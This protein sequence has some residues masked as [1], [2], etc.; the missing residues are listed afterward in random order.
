MRQIVVLAAAVA[1][2]CLLQK[3]AGSA[4]PTAPEEKRKLALNLVKAKVIKNLETEPVDADALSGYISAEQKK[5]SHTTEAGSRQLS[6]NWF[7]Q[8]LADGYGEKMKALIRDFGPFDKE[9]EKG[10]LQIPVAP[11]DKNIKNNFPNGF[12]NARNLAIDKQKE[13]VKKIEYPSAGEFESHEENPDGLQNFLAG[14]L[15]QLNGVNLFDENKGWLKETKVSGIIQKAQEERGQQKSV[16]E[17]SEGGNQV[18]PSRIKANI[19][20]EL[21][22]SVEGKEFGIFPSV[23]SGTEPRSCSLAA[24]KFVGA[25]GKMNLKVPKADIKAFIGQDLEGHKSLNQSEEKCVAHFQESITSRAI[26]QYIKGAPDDSKT[27]LQAFLGRVSNDNEEVKEALKKLTAE[28]VSASLK[29]A[30]NELAEGQLTKFFK[31]LAG[32]T[33]KPPAEEIEKR[34]SNVIVS[35]PNP[36]DISGIS[37]VKPTEALLEETEEKVLQ[38][39]KELLGEGLKAFRSQMEILETLKEELAADLEKRKE[40]PSLPELEEEFRKGLNREWPKSESGAAL[41]AKYPSSS[42]YFPLV[43]KE[44]TE[45][46]KALLQR[47]SLKRLEKIIEAHQTTVSLPTSPPL[48]QPGA[49]KESGKG[50]NKGGGGGGG[51]GGGDGGGADGGEGKK[52][53]DLEINVSY[54]GKEVSVAI[55]P[56]NVTMPDHKLTLTLQG[57][58]VILSDE[59]RERTLEYFKSW[60]EQSLGN[61]KEKEKELFVLVKVHQESTP[62]AAV[63]WVRR[64]LKSAVESIPPPAEQG[65]GEN[66]KPKV[67]WYDGLSKDIEKDIPKDQPPTEEMRNFVREHSMAM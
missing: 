33:W 61:A 23:A 36:L 52:G 32:R 6:E 19:L 5:G 34:R 39:E 20:G 47:E 12:R 44:I 11:I 4:E 15:T 3:N 43:D 40:L 60:L 24:N 10:I 66:P 58:S 41:S 37:S 9:F 2:L 27:E 14:R 16:V 21:R 25:C 54:K 7:R 28:S 38:A 8:K 50:P 51:G 65:P 59:M 53:F 18:A 17:N 48:P 30:R 45:K 13:D 29:E 1:F 56:R 26:A 42:R 46:A 62:Y 57:D 22:K 67:Y 55:T 35:V 63:Y 31:P 49:G 64:C